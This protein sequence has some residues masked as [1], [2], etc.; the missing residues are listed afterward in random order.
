[1][2]ITAF[3]VTLCLMVICACI[4]FIIAAALAA[5]RKEALAHL[6]QKLAETAAERD[7]AEQVAREFQRQLIA[8]HAELEL[9]RAVDRIIGG[10]P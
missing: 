8:A 7:H 3:I 6:E 5:D 10:L 4:G 1:M 2:S 9:G